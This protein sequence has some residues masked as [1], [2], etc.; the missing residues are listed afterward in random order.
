MPCV[1]TKFE[2]F[3]AF[4][5]LLENL[6]LKIYERDKIAKKFSNEFEHWNEEPA[7]EIN[8]WICLKYKKLLGLFKK[9]KTAFFIARRDEQNDTKIIDFENCF[10]LLK[11]KHE[12]EF[13]CQ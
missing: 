7:P 8:L 11:R 5:A 9:R 2:A 3:F 1:S 12:S 6:T 13:S 4:T 10:G